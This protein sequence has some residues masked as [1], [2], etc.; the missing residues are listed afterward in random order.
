MC[1]YTGELELKC[2]VCGHKND[3]TGIILSLFIIYIS[4]AYYT[5]TNIEGSIKF[6][7][8]AWKEIEFLKFVTKMGVSIGKF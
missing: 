8:E 7:I 6:V 5:E 3:S 1:K 4:F 2:T